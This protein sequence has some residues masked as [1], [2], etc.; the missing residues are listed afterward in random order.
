MAHEP[1]LASTAASIIVGSYKNDAFVSDDGDATATAPVAEAPP[2]RY[3]GTLCEI[4]LRSGS[5]VEAGKQLAGKTT[6]AGDAKRI[7]Y[8]DALDVIGEVTVFAAQKRRGR[9]PAAWNRTRSFIFVCVCC[10]KVSVACKSSC[11]SSAGP[12]S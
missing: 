1:S 6:G 8:D 3:V 7:T 9:V 12:S 5:V 10:W 11:F 4:D 2:F